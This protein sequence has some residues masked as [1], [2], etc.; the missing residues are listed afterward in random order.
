MGARQ[1]ARRGLLG[2]LMATGL[3]EAVT[4]SCELAGPR[5]GREDPHATVGEVLSRAT[6]HVAFDGASAV[7]K[8]LVVF[9]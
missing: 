7:R 6:D 8:L 2:G 5:P 1:L 9:S 4:A 3:S